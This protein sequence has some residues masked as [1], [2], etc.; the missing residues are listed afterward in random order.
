[1]VVKK[2]IEEMFSRKDPLSLPPN[3]PGIENERFEEQPDNSNNDND[4]TID[5][6]IKEISDYFDELG[7]Q[8]EILEIEKEFNKIAEQLKDLNLDLGEP[9]LVPAGVSSYY[10]ENKKN[11]DDWFIPPSN[12]PSSDISSVSDSVMTSSSPATDNCQAFPHSVSVEDK[13]NKL[14]DINSL[15]Q[16]SWDRNYSLKVIK[17]QDGRKIGVVGR[18]YR[19]KVVMTDK[20]AYIYKRR[21]I[22]NDEREWVEMEGWKDW[23]YE[24][25]LSNILSNVYRIENEDINSIIEALQSYDYSQ[26]REILFDKY[27]FGDIRENIL[28][29]VLIDNFLRNIEGNY[30]LKLLVFHVS[31]QGKVKAEEVGEYTFAFGGRGNIGVETNG[32]N[33]AVEGKLHSL[34][35]LKERNLLEERLRRAN[36]TEEEIE[37][38]L[39][40]ADNRWTTH[41]SIGFAFLA[42]YGI[43]EY[44]I[45]YVFPMKDFFRKVKHR[46]GWDGKGV[47]ISMMTDFVVLNVPELGEGNYG[48]S[49]EGSYVFVPIEFKEKNKT[50]LDRIPKE[51][52]VQY[53]PLNKIIG[54]E[55]LINLA[56]SVFIYNTLG[57]ILPVKEIYWAHTLCPTFGKDVYKEIERVSEE[58]GL[59][60]HKDI[61]PG[62]DTLPLGEKMKIAEEIRQIITSTSSPFADN[63][64]RE[65]KS[66]IL[67]GEVGRLFRKLFNKV[68]RAIVNVFVS[69]NKEMTIEYTEHVPSVESSKEDVAYFIPQTKLI[70]ADKKGGE[71][72]IYEGAALFTHG[73]VIKGVLSQKRKGIPIS[74]YIKALLEEREE[75]RQIAVIACNSEEG[76]INLSEIQEE[77]KVIYPA[78]NVEEIP[79]SLYPEEYFEILSQV[80]KKE[81]NKYF[82][83]RVYCAQEWRKVST[84]QERKKYNEGYTTSSSIEKKEGE[85]KEVETALKRDSSTKEKIEL[86]EQ[87][88]EIVKGLDK[89]QKEKLA[90]YVFAILEPFTV[91]KS[92]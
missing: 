73:E 78:G 26:I 28:T 8:L 49:L 64:K 40:D 25:R 18:G 82:D 39:K 22:W 61:N 33:P 81:M 47:N 59:E 63:D 55:S 51:T 13:V 44:P 1:E 38:Y 52:K 48:I 14:L 89:I 54:N 67:T 4:K 34:R 6:V 83:Y 20:E 41:F 53:Y 86:V 80:D 9:E 72:I 76:K 36:K 17:G 74:D 19:V 16:C 37:V 31:R 15:G 5:D 30:S 68:V 24:Q 92:R 2:A 87:I 70:L 84:Y 10:E 7:K 29:I 21:D 71:P 23:G 58:I 56:I 46:C 79:A 62:F 66:S 35:T 32:I 45:I 11:S 42:P 91:K 75:I 85:L 69:Y 50:L 43:S 77:L 12:G 65:H 27:Y 90:R 60:S 3:R 57:L 88:F